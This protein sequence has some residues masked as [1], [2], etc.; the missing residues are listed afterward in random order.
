MANIGIRWS[1]W[2][3]ISGAFM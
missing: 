2:N 1:D 3:V